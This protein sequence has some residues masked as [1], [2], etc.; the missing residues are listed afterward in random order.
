MSPWEPSPHVPGCVCR[1]PTRH[2]TKTA[3]AT[4]EVPPHPLRPGE[5]ARILTLTGSR[6][7]DIYDAFP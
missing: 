1:S 6:L 4:P 2:K 7:V 5:N 3:M